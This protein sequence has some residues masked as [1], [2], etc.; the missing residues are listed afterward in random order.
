[1]GTATSFSRQRRDDRTIPTSLDR[2]EITRF[3]PFIAQ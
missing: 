2:S 3:I 1:M